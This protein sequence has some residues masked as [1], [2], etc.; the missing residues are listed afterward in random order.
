MNLAVLLILVHLMNLSA[1]IC[2]ETYFASVSLFYVCKLYS[3]VMKL[4]KPLENTC[5]VVHY[6]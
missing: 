6:H 1:L 3:A 5:L 4:L 2:K